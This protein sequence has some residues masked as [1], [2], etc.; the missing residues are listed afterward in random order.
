MVDHKNVEGNLE[1]KFAAKGFISDVDPRPPAA[2][3]GARDRRLR[4]VERLGIVAAGRK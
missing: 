3:P 1:Q 4:L 2:H